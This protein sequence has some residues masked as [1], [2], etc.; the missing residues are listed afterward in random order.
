MRLAPR[1]AQR[2]AS[3]VVSRFLPRLPSCLGLCVLMVALTGCARQ[4]RPDAEVA[5]RVEREDRRLAELTAVAAVDIEPFELASAS[6][7]IET[8]GLLY[9]P[10]RRQAPPPPE[11]TQA[12]RQPG[13]LEGT[14][15]WLAHPWAFPASAD[16]TGLIEPGA[17]ALADDGDDGSDDSNSGSDRERGRRAKPRI[18]VN[19]FNL[20]INDRPVSFSGSAKGT[21]SVQLRATIRM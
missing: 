3:N 18:R 12:P 16:W 8:L 15:R 7:A 9:V 19:L 10:D 13:W 20:R 17:Q 11:P 4:A 6:V 14:P 2:F 21:D 1:P 5:K